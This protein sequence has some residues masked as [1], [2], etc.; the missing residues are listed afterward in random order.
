MPRHFSIAP[1]RYLPAAPRLPQRLL[2]RCLRP[3]LREEVLG[4]LEEAYTAALRSCSPWRARLLYWYE[5]V[6]YLRF[7]ILAKRGKKID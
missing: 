1:R 5:A 3:H 4:D 6:S 7:A 2:V